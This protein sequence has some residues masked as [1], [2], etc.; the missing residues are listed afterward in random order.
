[1]EAQALALGGQ[2]DVMKQQVLDTRQANADM[3][4][5]IQMQARHMSGKLKLSRNRLTRL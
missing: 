2:I 4:A 5:A 3:L 1:M